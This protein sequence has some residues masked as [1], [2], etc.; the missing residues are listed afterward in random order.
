MSDLSVTRADIERVQEIAYHYKEHVWT[1][2]SEVASAEILVDFCEVLLGRD[3]VD[4][5]LCSQ[6]MD[7]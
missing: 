7:G 6:D 1:A 4:G 3:T 2:D 5:F